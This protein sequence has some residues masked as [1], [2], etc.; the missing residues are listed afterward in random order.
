MVWLQSG[1]L[2]LH[3]LGAIF[4]F[5]SGLFLQHVV[6]PSLERLPF[7]GQKSLLGSIAERYGRYIGPLALLTVLL[8]ILRGLSVGV[9]GILDTPYGITWLASIAGAIAVIGIG[10]RFVGPTAARMA[11]ASSREE[12]LGHA[13][14]IRRYGGA[15][16]AGMLGMLVLMVAM[17]AGY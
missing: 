14:R 16:R 13:A 2:Y 1:L 7:E 12:L 15:E 4:W 6:V 17:R 5:G 11:A 10:V 3:I 9:L 8:G